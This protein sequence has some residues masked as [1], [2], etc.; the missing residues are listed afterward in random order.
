MHHC[1]HNIIFSKNQAVYP[2]EY[3][4][5]ISQLLIRRQQIKDRAASLAKVIHK[6]YKGKRPV[7]LCVL[8]GSNPFFQNLCEALQDLRQGFYTEYIRVSSYEGTQSTKK[9]MISGGIKYENVEGKDVILIEDIV[10]TGTTLLQLIPILKEEAKPLSIEVCT[11]LARQFAT[12]PKSQAKYVGFLIPSAAFVI[13]YGLDYNEWGRDLQD[14][15][16]ISQKGIEC[17]K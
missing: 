8:K 17:L 4:G 5:H 10:D 9:L 13:G 6:D 2:P 14:I 15:W 7:L 11:L 3:E 12:P 1:P 16:V